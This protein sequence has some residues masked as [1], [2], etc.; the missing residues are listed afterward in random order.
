M[1]LPRLPLKWSSAQSAVPQC[2]TKSSITIFT[3]W[4][5]PTLGRQRYIASYTLSVQSNL[6][7]SRTSFTLQLFTHPALGS[8]DEQEHTEV[9]LSCWP[10][11]V[12]TLRYG[13]MTCMSIRC[14]WSPM[15]T[16]RHRRPEESLSSSLSPGRRF[17]VATG[18]S[19]GQAETRQDSQFQ[20]QVEASWPLTQPAHCCSIL[21]TTFIIQ[22]ILILPWLIHVYTWWI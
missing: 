7:L 3:V 12:T 14:S 9:T 15:I 6:N 13:L 16:V 20:F 11:C 17:A 5:L 18:V 22:L 2:I 4:Y 10:P 1:F 21:L 19:S 8:A